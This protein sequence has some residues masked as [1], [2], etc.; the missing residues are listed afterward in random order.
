MCWC[1]GWG[2]RDQNPTYNFSVSIF[3]IAAIETS[4]ADRVTIILYPL[5]T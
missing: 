3:W 5:I 1:V 2:E 4:S